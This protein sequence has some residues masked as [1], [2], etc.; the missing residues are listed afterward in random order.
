MKKRKS[1]MKKFII[2]VFIVILVLYL[3]RNYNTIILNGADFISDLI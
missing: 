2:F 3:C 1:G